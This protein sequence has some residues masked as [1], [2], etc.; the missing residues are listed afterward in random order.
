MRPRRAADDIPEPEDGSR[1][2]HA[3]D[4][5]PESPARRSPASPARVARGREAE[6]SSQDTPI[7]VEPPSP[8]TARGYAGPEGGDD[9]GR[10]GSWAGP[11]RAAVF[12]VLALA[13]GAGSALIPAQR[14]S[15]VTVPSVTPGQTLVCS[16]SAEDASVVVAS[17]SPT[18]QT[19]GL[20]G[21]LSDT[22]VPATSAIRKDARLV[23]SVSGQGRP[24]ATT[25]STVGSGAGAM[26]TMNVCTTALSGGSISVADPA[27]S[28]IVVTNPDASDAT[29]DVALNGAKGPVTS[30]GSQGIAVPSHSSKVLPLS[31]WVAGAGPVTADITTESGRIVA[32]ARTAGAAGRSMYNM[33]QAGQTLLLPAA[34]GKSSGS[35]LMLSN[36]GGA[37]AAVAVKALGARGAFTPEGAD[38]VEV[39]PHSTITVDMGRAFGGESVALQVSADSSVSAQL[40]ST[41]GKDST[42]GVPVGSGTVLQGAVPAGGTLAVSNPSSSTATVKGYYATGNGQKTEVTMSVSPG[43]TVSRDLGAKAGQLWLRSSGAAIFGGVWNDR[44]GVSAMPL[45]VVSGPTTG[46]RIGVDPQLS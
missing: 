37:R 28:D 3:A 11:A 29:V 46:P 33:T 24:V 15:D 4:P 16:P 2:R 9:P 13:V 22:R 30:E 31:V 19:G 1:P 6:P 8:G 45:S 38:Q 21:D 18:L 14:A 10:Q 27:Q 39:E 40:L 35:E 44:A 41:K 17:T 20:T 12:A 26:S 23:R 34:P 5:S 36:P 43:A 7:R 25:Y 32:S 42:M